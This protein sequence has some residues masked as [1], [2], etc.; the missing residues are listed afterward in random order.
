LNRLTGKKENG[1]YAAVNPD[2]ELMIQKLGLFEDAF[3]SLMLNQEQIPKDL[4]LLR[5]QGKEKTVTYKEKMTRKLINNNIV[6]F[7]ES[8]G[9]R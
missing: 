6:M 5:V 4:E 7:F 9:I 8:H 2:T 1:N 3:E